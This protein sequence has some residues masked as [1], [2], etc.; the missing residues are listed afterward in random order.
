MPLGVLALML[1]QEGHHQ[2]LDLARHPGKAKGTHARLR[3]KDRPLMNDFVSDAEFERLLAAWFGNIARVLVPGGAYYLWGGYANC[4]NYPPAL[5]AA[6][7]YFAQA[8]IW[9]KQHPVLT[10]KD[11]MGAHEWCF[12]G[13]RDGAGHHFYGPANRSQRAGCDDSCRAW[14][15]ARA[16]SSAS[17]LTVCATP[18]PPN[19]VPRASTLP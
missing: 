1:V 9:D 13:W 6:G 19:S 5:E 12:Y 18:T 17:T 16:S 2:E 7:L 15:A 10:R 4:G 14:L 3:A 11:F 8:I